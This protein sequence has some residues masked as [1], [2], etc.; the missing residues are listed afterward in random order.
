M[1]GFKVKKMVT[2]PLL[3]IKPGVEYYIRV[4]GPMHEGKKIDDRKEPAI[5]MNVQELP[6][7]KPAQIIVGKLMRDALN[8]Q[9]PNS[10]YV[11]KCFA[12]QIDKDQNNPERKYN[13]LTT[14]NEI[15]PDES[16]VSVPKAAG[17]KK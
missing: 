15:E 14:L 17:A 1:A 7:N 9:Y 6:T 13:L 3:K 5:L 8:E 11:G 2:V 10:A 16:E 4:T 12:F